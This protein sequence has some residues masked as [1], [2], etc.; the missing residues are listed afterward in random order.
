MGE[1][2]HDVKNA[3]EEIRQDLRSLRGQLPMP[4]AQ[5]YFS[6]SGY[7]PEVSNSGIDHPSEQIWLQ[8]DVWEP[9]PVTS[10][11]QPRSELG[12]ADDNAASS[13]RYD[14]NKD[15]ETLL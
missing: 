5:M 11:T 2:K 13:C 6:G 3:V 9:L 15:I 7:A 14:L 12:R 10:T 8:N 1:L 4:T